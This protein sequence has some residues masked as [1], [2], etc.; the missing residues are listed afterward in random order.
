MKW[1][2]NNYENGYREQTVL[3][4]AKNILDPAVLLKIA[5]ISDAVHTFSVHLDNGKLIS[6]KDLCLR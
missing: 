3:I 1:L 5:R 6:W 4:Q 2:T